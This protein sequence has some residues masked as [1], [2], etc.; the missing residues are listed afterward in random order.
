MQIVDGKII[1]NEE[2]QEFL[3]YMVSLNIIQ[4]ISTISLRNLAQI[5]YDRGHE[6][7]INY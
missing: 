1:L 4:D 6:D 3:A 2:D 7:A 5:W